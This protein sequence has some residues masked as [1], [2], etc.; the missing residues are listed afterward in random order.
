MTVEALRTRRPLTIGAIAVIA[1]AGI[2]L[3]GH[4]FGGRPAGPIPAADDKR[5]AVQSEAIAALGRVE[6]QSEI[7]N[8]GAGSASDRLESLE[9][10]RD[11][12]VTKGQALGYLGGYAE[13]IAQR[14]MTAAQ[15]YEAKA[16][17]RSEVVLDTVRLDGALLHQRQVAELTPLRIAQQQAI[18]D[19]L[20]ARRAN[21]ADKL[22]AQMKLFANGNSTRR[23]TADEQSMVL[24]DEANLRSARVKLTEL[25]KQF[26]LDKLDADI[27]VK[28]AEATLERMQAE[29]PIASLERSVALAQAR[30][31]RM[32]LRAPID[33]RILN[34]LTKPGENVGSGP[35]LTMGDT[36]RMRAVAEV[37]ETDIGRVQIGQMATIHSRALAKPMTG[38]V[39]R[40]GDIVFKNNVLNVDPAARADARVVEVWI[41]LD[42]ASPVERL[43]NLTVDVVIGD[44]SPRT[45]APR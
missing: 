27:Q 41:E 31:E 18:I 33:G 12:I 10:A 17:L 35:I 36:S 28:Q 32:T 42:D 2:L 14:D 38:E 19:G 29:F 4:F 7:I 39:V 40:I 44:T 30:A 5:A 24:Q 16:K 23:L 15:V 25:T 9:V 11:D 13:Q 21:S 43:T 26:E 8:L 20:D 37:Y 34:I 1:V 3:S 45:A 22:D 6:P